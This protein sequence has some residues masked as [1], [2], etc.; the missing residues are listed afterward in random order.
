MVRQIALGRDLVLS[1]K[2]FELVG[3]EIRKNFVARNKGRHI[4][5]IRERLHLLVGLSISPHIDLGEPKAAF[6]Q[7]ILRVNTP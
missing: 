5:L 2:C 7:V 6:F 4:S 1:Q 3:I